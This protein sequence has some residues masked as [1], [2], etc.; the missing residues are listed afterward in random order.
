MNNNVY[1][2]D[3]GTTNLKVFSKS[4]GKIF[5]EKNTIA[6]RGKYEIFAYGD[7]AY[8][9]YEKAPESIQVV[10]P[11]ISGVIAEFQDM[12][13]FIYAFLD[14]KMQSKKFRVRRCCPD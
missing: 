13:D 6:L 8:A 11:V 3:L 2:I 12:E 1:G 5:I 9:M 14:D 10:F 7:K 4:N